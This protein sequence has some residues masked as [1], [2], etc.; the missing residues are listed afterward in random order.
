MKF[1]YAPMEG[2]GGYLYRNTHRTFF[3]NIDKYFAPFI[4]ADHTKGFKTKDRNDI[5]PANNDSLKLIPQILT[6]NSEHYINTSKKIS[7]FG[8]DEINLN[9]GCPSTAVVSGNR[10]SGFLAHRDE[11][12]RFLED[13]FRDPVTEISIKT[14]L[15]KENHDEFY[16]LIEIFNKYP[17]KELIIHP[18]IQTDIYNNKPNLEVFKDALEL[19]KNKVVYNGDI[20]K[21]SDYKR[22]VEMFPSVDTVML[23]R[24]L[25]ANPALVDAILGGR[26]PDKSTIK[27]FHDKLY[28]QY[29]GI[30][31]E[32]RY[33]LS[34]M[35]ESWFYMIQAF[36]D[37]K[38]YHRQIMK[39]T[40][41]KDYYEVIS[42][43][44]EEREVLD[45]YG[46]FK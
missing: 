14:R 35:K 33:L 27:N 36:D 7:A 26:G 41:K 32:E 5:L 30:I 34:K 22:I 3:N 44:F 23:G 16:K 40:T 1:Y 37:H 29:E 19:S 43:L 4:V 24:G 42:R 18:R 31:L 12:D 9:L 11:L 17:M 10:G 38:D 25:L 20:F 8:Y 13:I 15:G 21:V 2:I 28:E 39:S 6:N 45:E 46:Y